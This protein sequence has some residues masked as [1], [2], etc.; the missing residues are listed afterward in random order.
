[1]APPFTI[2]SLDNLGPTDGGGDDSLWRVV[3]SDPSHEHERFLF[4][5]PDRGGTPT[6]A[7]MRE[8][9]VARAAS[10]ENDRGAVDSSASARPLT[11]PDT[12]NVAR[13][14]S[15]AS[16]SSEAPPYDAAMRL[17]AVL[18]ACQ[19]DRARDLASDP[20]GRPD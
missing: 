16:T 3:I 13:Y 10:F 19:E 11:R 8:R 1:M 14:S 20:V 18:D 6:E 12:R 7:Q 4:A 9:I 2:E 17:R 5:F 15:A